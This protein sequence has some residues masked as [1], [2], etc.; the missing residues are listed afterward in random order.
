MHATTSLDSVIGLVLAGGLSRRMNGRAKAFLPFGNDC[1]LTR[2]L[3]RFAPQVQSVVLSANGHLDRFASFNL[4][5]V[6]DVRSDYAG[7]L[8]GIEAAF[9]ATSAAW[10]VSVPVDLPFMPMDLVARLSDAAKHTG[11][12]SVAQSGER[13]HPVVCLWPRSALPDIQSAL[14]AGN[15][16]MM[17]WLATHPH[18]V[19]LF[20]VDSE[21]V[22]PFFNI[23]YPDS[24]AQALRL[25]DDSE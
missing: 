23:N 20:K 1:L 15:R 2:V 11:L 9:L 16:R 19:V 14:D 13:I 8:A 18:Q 5:I 25:A 22:D 6:V 10:I 21:G 17:A 3:Q 4:P 24:L 7:P 12:P